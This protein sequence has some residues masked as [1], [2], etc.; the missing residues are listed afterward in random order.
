MIDSFGGPEALQELLGD[1]AELL[2]AAPQLGIG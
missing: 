2:L 1:A